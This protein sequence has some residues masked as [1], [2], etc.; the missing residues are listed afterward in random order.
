M[1]RFS[2]LIDQFRGERGKNKQLLT[3]GRSPFF[4]VLWKS[5]IFCQPCTGNR[6]EGVLLSWIVSVLKRKTTCTIRPVFRDFPTQTLVIASFF[7]HDASTAHEE[8]WYFWQAVLE[9]LWFS[10]VYVCICQLEEAVV[11]CH[12]VFVSFSLCARLWWGS[13]CLLFAFDFQ[14]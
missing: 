8:T 13:Q 1:A 4:F 14:C 11:G 7:P 2:E 5:G 10:S 9:T 12:G 3:V 6:G